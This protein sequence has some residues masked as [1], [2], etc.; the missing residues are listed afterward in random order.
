MRLASILIA[1][2]LSLTAQADIVTAA[3]ASNFR[4]TAER[5]AADFALQTGHELR[6][7]SGSTGKLHA[8]ITYGAPF[9]VF[10]AADATSPRL[11]EESGLGVTG[12]RFTYAIGEL[13]LW[14]AAD[15]VVDCRQELENLGNFRLAIANPE[16]APYGHAAREFLLHVGLW[17]RLVPQL[18]YGENIAQALHFA[19]SGNARYALIA[20]SQA[21]DP[22]LPAATCS[23]AVPGATHA[24]LLHQAVLLQRAA[25]NPAARSFLHYL[26]GDAAR[27]TID[28]SGYGVP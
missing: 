26:Q 15:G 16:T 3:V 6:I 19:V 28:R 2:L 14:S 17:E 1:S 25:A 27:A 13:V 23:W 18:V 7:S 5:L 4:A 20:R 8:Q 9:D 10:L 24:A 21:I 22:R 11:L 12:S